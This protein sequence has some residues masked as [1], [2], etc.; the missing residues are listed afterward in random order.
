MILQLYKDCSLYGSVCSQWQSNWLKITTI[1]G[2]GRRRLS[3]KLKVRRS[4]V[5]IK[6]INPMCKFSE[7]H[8]ILGTLFI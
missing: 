3:F 4:G 6:K 5:Q 7:I 8:L 1:P 2:A